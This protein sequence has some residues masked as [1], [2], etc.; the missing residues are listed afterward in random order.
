MELPFIP[1]RT[2]L[3]DLVWISLS[4]AKNNFQIHLLPRLPGHYVN[5]GI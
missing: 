3:K 2:F 4:E 5:I 1:V